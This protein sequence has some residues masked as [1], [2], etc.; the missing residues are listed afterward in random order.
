MLHEARALRYRYTLSRR[1]PEGTGTC[2]FVMLNPSTADSRRDDPTIRRC[3]GFARRWGFGQLRVVNLFALRAT[4]PRGLRG[5]REPT[6]VVGPRND[7][8]LHREVR[9][10]DVVV[11]AWGAHGT[12][13]DRAARVLEGL[14]DVDWQCLGTTRTGQPRHPLMLRGDTKLRPLHSS[15]P[16][17]ASA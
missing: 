10:A 15:R 8:V 1:F 16:S 11:A 14:P 3:I 13:H 4:D 7:A 5:A 17:P 9:R 2:L 6:H 12:L